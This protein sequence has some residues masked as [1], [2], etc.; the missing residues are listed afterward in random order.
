M[1]TELIDTYTTTLFD[2]VRENKQYN[3]ILNSCNNN[4]VRHFVIHGEI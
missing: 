3:N 2:S 4:I 1:K